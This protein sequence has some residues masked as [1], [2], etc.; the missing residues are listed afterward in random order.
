MKIGQKPELPG[1][2]AQTG[3]AKQAKSPASAAEGAAKDAAAVSTAGVPVTVS[4]AAR[5]LD[6]TSRSTGD[7]DASK[8]KAVRS[9]IEKGTFS[10]DAEAIADKMLSNAQEIL[11]RSRG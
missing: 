2:L 9:A 3:L 11:A 5:A 1:A 7:F 6:Q 4:T 10:V 8:V